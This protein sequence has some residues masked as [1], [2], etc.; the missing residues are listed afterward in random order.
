MG[1]CQLYL[2]LFMLSFP[3]QCHT[4]DDLI[5]GKVAVFK[6]CLGFRLNIGILKVSLKAIRIQPKIFYLFN[7]FVKLIQQSFEVF[8]LGKFY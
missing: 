2:F 4:Q 3:P 7:L 5:D 6:D 1:A 8:F